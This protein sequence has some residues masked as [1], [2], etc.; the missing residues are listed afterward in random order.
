[1]TRKNHARPEVKTARR[2][3]CREPEPSAQASTA[4]LL[5]VN[6]QLRREIDMRRR[7]ESEH[8]RLIDELRKALKNVAFNGHLPLCA[9]CRELHDDN[10]GRTRPDAFR[11]RQRTGTFDGDN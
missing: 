5:K 9:C 7:V 3:T 8:L 4:E 10:G 1:M 2:R 11:S 6:D